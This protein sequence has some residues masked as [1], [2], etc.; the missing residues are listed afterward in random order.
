[1]LWRLQ[2]FHTANAGHRDA[3]ICALSGSPKR[4]VVGALPEAD[5]WLC[6]WHLREKLRLRRVRAKA[7]SSSD[8]V[9]QRLERC[10]HSH[11]DSEQFCSAYRHRPLLREVRRAWIDRWDDAVRAQLDPTPGEVGA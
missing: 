5:I 11:H 1:M 6:E 2:A 3:F 8:R 4:V 9:W 10:M 7:N